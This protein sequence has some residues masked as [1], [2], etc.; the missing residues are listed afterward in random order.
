M[1]NKHLRPVS[2]KRSEPRPMTRSF[3]VKWAC[4]VAL[5]TRVP[6]LL[7][8]HWVPSRHVGAP[9]GK[10]PWTAAFAPSL[11]VDLEYT[12]EP[13]CPFHRRS[14]PS[15]CWR[16]IRYLDLFAPLAPHGRC[17]Q[18]AVLAVGR[19][20]PMKPGKVHTWLRH[21]RRQCSFTC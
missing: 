21:Q 9:L 19:K 8:A 17:N 5:T 10:T 16:L 14:P 13:L 6:V 2:K 20:H 1:L 4:L 11:D 15:G 7:A 3:S 18:G 12:L